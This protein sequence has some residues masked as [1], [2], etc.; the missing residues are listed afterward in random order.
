MNGETWFEAF[1]MD[2]GGG[3][4]EWPCGLVVGFDEGC[5]MSLQLAERSYGGNWVTM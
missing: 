2:L 4:F 5:D 3:P 1:L